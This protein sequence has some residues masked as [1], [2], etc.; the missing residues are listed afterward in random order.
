[1]WNMGKRDVVVLFCDKCLLNHVEVTFSIVDIHSFF[2]FFYIKRFCLSRR[3]SHSTTR[4]Q[5]DKLKMLL[6][7]MRHLLKCVRVKGE[8]TSV[9][10]VTCHRCIPALVVIP[11]GN[12]VWIKVRVCQRRA[13]LWAAAC[14][15]K[16]A[17][18]FTC[19]SFVF[20]P[21][22]QEALHTSTGVKVLTGLSLMH[23]LCLGNRVQSVQDNLLENPSYGK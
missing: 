13:E 10:W 9:N 20:V 3:K 5:G 17:H 1:M 7:Q 14:Q 6:S 4:P 15:P 19:G 2:V 8:K 11:P 16:G 23:P 12:P 21:L 22:L 18:T